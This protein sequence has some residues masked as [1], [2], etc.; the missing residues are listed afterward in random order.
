[1]AAAAFTETVI[2]K[3]TRDG[4][5]IHIRMTVSDVASAYAIAP[6]GNGFIQLPGDQDYKLSDVIV[7]TGGTDTTQQLIFANS[8]NTGLVLDNKSN[9]NT[10]NFRQFLTSPVAFKAGSLIRFQQAA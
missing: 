9:L 7:V 8:L 10:A 4:R 3:G 2:L 6:D 5:T 1:M